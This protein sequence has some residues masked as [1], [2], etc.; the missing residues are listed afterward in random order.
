ML[1]CRQAGTGGVCGPTGGSTTEGIRYR[2]LLR[3][4]NWIVDQ[5]PLWRFPGE[6][7]DTLRKLGC[8]ACLWMRVMPFVE[9]ALRTL[10]RV[11]DPGARL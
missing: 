10:V 4:A 8:Y 2:Q 1:E 9:A 6:E 5:F 7:Q 3:M 11:P